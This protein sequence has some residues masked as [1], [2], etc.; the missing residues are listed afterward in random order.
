[1]PSAW[2]VAVTLTLP[3]AEAAYAASC[4]ASVEAAYKCTEK[5]RN[6]ALAVKKPQDNGSNFS[7]TCAKGM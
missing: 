7:P 1:M 3:G 4:S 6:A 2:Q 5:D